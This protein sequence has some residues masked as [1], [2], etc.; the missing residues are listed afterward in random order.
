VSLQGN[1][2]AVGSVLAA[3]DRHE[4]APRR[5]GAGWQARYPADDDW[6]PGLPRT[7]RTRAVAAR[8][9]YGDVA[10]ARHAKCRSTDERRLANA[11][12]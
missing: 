1:G 10:D 12:A 8:H 5:A 11:S 2:V 6:R 9:P 3:L 4:C 7:E